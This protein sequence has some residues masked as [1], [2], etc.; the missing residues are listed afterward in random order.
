[1]KA[2]GSPRQSEP[3]LN[4]LNI[5]ARDFDKALEFYRRLGVPVPKGSTSPDGIRHAEVTLANGFVLE[6]DNLP[7]A[8][9]Y[10]AAWR[11]PEGS[12]RAL[13]GFSLATREAVDATYA[14][15]TAAGY[16]GRQPPYDTFWG[17]RYAVVADPD[18]NDVG[19]MSPLD[20]SR[21]SWPPQESPGP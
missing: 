9:V 14:E 8:R 6:F 12:S 19:L 16:E 11:R 21:R 3:S 4:Q 18:G 13:I 1:L 10:N 2:A 5:V 17:A 20:D 15:L 7:L